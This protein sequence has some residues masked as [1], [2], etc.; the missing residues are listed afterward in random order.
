MAWIEVHQ[1]LPGHRKT[2]KAAK[3]LRLSRAAVVGHLVTLWLWALDNAPSGRVD[4]IGHE[5]LADA[6]EYGGDPAGFVAALVESGFLENRETG[7]ILIHDWQEYAGKLIFRREKDRLRKRE[8][9]EISG[10]SAGCERDS[11][12]VPTDV[13]RNSAATVQYSTLEENLPETA[14]SADSAPSL[15]LEIPTPSPKGRTRYP[16]HFNDWW[17]PWQQLG[18]DDDKPGTWK[19]YQAWEKQVGREGLTRARDAYLGHCERERTEPRFIKHAYKFLD[20]RAAFVTQ[21]LERAAEQVDE[22]ADCYVPEI[23]E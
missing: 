17:K 8:N 10:N 6:A 1:S 15:D 14:V 5:V 13:R 21:W 2:R 4:Q 18:R 16:A 20:P 19:R 23:D 9:R 3:L 11:A 22:Q 12:G 7:E